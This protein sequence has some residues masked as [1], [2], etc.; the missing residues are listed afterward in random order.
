MQPT[1]AAPPATPLHDTS[2][3]VVACKG[4]GLHCLP[5]CPG[6]RAGVLHQEVSGAAV[7]PTHAGYWSSWQPF[8]VCNDP[9][10]KQFLGI[11]ADDIQIGF[12]LA[13]RASPA[14]LAAYRAPRRGP[15]V[16]KI[17]WK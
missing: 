3:L 8:E 16:D 11:D 12:F 15:M 1:S 7:V 6:K 14:T 5:A 9:E 13:G 2:A 17:I 10:F 4:A